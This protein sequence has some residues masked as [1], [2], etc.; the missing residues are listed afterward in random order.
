MSDALTREVELCTQFRKRCEEQA[1][2]NERLR[3][4]LR[5]YRDETPLGHQPHMIA[6]EVDDV[7]QGGGD[8]A[9]KGRMMPK[10]EDHPLWPG[11]WQWWIRSGKQGWEPWR[12]W[13]GCWQAAA[14]AVALP[15]KDGDHA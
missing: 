11:F 7:L 2:V 12:P 5:R 6:G 4:L 13:W 1:D 15:G 14:E 9:G 10:P 8:P 3:G